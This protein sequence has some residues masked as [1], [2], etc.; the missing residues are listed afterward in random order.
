MS[1]P[2]YAD[3]KLDNEKLADEENVPTYLGDRD[4]ANSISTL[5]ALIAEGEGFF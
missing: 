4:R 1:T 5:N 3:E 2:A